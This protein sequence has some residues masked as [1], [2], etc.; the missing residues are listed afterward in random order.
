MNLLQLP[1]NSGEAS[2]SGPS[3]PDLVDSTGADFTFL[4]RDDSCAEL[5]TCLAQRYFCH[6]LRIKDKQQHP[7][8][9]LA[10]GP[11]SGKSRFLQELPHYFASFVQT[12][13]EYY[14][15]LIQGNRLNPKA[16]AYVQQHPEAFA[17]FKADMASSHYCTISF[18]GATVYAEEAEKACTIE[19]SICLRLLYP[20]HH[21]TSF[22]AFVHAYLQTPKQLVT[23]SATVDKIAKGSTCA[24]LGIDEIS[25]LYAASPGK[26]NALFTQ[27]GGLCATNPLFLFAV[28]AGTNIRAITVSLRESSYAPLHVPLPLLSFESSMQIVC[29][30][31]SRFLSCASHPGFAQ[32]MSEVGGHCRAL[33]YLYEHLVR[34]ADAHF[35]NCLDQVLLSTLVDLAKVYD[36]ETLGLDVAIAYSFLP[37]L[38]PATKWK[39]SFTQMH[40][41]GLLRFSR[42]T[43]PAVIV[44]YIFVLCYLTFVPNPLTRFW[45]KCLLDQHMQWQDWEV[46]G[47]S[48]VAFRLSLFTVLE[49]TTLP[50]SEFLSGATIHCPNDVSITLP[51]NQSVNCIAIP[52]QFP[53]TCKGSFSNGEC[54]LNASGAPFDA[55]VYLQS[56]N[57]RLL[58]A[59]QMKFANATSVSPQQ[60]TI[61]TI[62]AEYEKSS[63]S[64]KMHLPETPFFFLLLA[65]CH[66]NYDLSNIPDNCAI[67]TIENQADFF[68]MLCM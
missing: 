13:A 53:S 51:P 67:V 56:T 38:L 23:L 2:S 6:K 32:L 40:E 12:S 7:I 15:R 61:K 25:K 66:G 64:I 55:F 30:K 5:A 10:D 34:F 35:L 26:F 4:D 28:F 9:I 20:Y 52:N 60:V 63:A 48:Y 62:E 24:V 36:F 65:H 16:S 19:E 57:C 39:V 50:L 46:F 8:P 29:Q 37:L 68:G 33:E 22:L 14:N 43:R 1:V 58:I 31:N 42:S 17:A 45:K 44:P 54:V 21:F 49:Y 27:I 41:K 11:G 3:S 47:C 59:M 18:A